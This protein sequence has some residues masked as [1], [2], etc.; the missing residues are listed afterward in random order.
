MDADSSK[1]LFEHNIDKKR[2]PA[3]LAKLMTAIIVFDKLKGNYDDLVTFSY[4]S[5][6]KDIDRTSATIGASAGDQL[7]V[8]D[9]L[10]SL[11]LPSANDAA[12][13]LAE[14]VAGNISD[15]ALLMN[16]KAKNIGLKNTHFVN[17]SGLHDDNQYTTAYDMAKIMQYALRYSIFLQISSSVSYRHAPIRKYKNPDNSNNTILNTNSI[18]VHGSGYYYNGIT[19]GKTGHTSLAGY[20]LAASAKR[21]G[22]HL[23][24]VCLGANSEKQ[25]FTDAKNLFDYYFNNYSSYAI[26]DFDKRFNTPIDTFSINDVSI[27][28]TLNI[29]CNESAHI[30][31]PKSTNLQDIKSKIT[32]QVKDIYNR[33]AI[34]YITY[35]LSGEFVGECTLEG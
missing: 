22:M 28:N 11:L 16:E 3:S 33:Y 18:M 5:V 7:S 14:H 34:G 1:V 20:N 12:N 35:T 29:T 31:V 25:R 23:I 4:T 19:A 13:A 15:F 26:K 2:F 8:K 17:P 6:T 27:L 10:Y 9:C 32:Y 24:C 21:D 30:T